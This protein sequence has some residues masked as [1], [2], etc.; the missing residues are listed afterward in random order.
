MRKVV[1]AVRHY[2]AIRARML[3]KPSANLAPGSFNPFLRGTFPHPRFLLEQSQRHGPVFKFSW[4]RNLSTAIVG[5]EAAREFLTL[6][7]GRLSGISQDLSLLGDVKHVRNLEGDVHSRCKQHLLR[8]MPNTGSKAHDADLRAH[9]QREL[10]AFADRCEREQPEADAFKHVLS[11]IATGMLITALFGLR[12]G[13]DS[14]N[15]ILKGFLK[16]GPKGL[17]WQLGP[18]QAQAY[19]ELE[20]TITELVDGMNETQL[21]QEDASFLKE[22]VRAA[23]S[24]RLVLI[25]LLAMTEMGRYDLA[26]FLRW[27]VCLLGR[28]HD[29]LSHLQEVGKRAPQELQQ[30]ASACVQECLRHVQSESLARRADTDI[31][32]RGHFIPR[33]TYVRICLW[34]THKDPAVF[35]DPFH[36]DPSRFVGKTYDANQFAPFGLDK[37]KCVAADTVMRLA[38]V[39]IEELT[40]SFTWQSLGDNAPVRPFSLWEPAPEFTVAMKRQNPVA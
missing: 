12:P 32:F 5:F 34:E 39:F 29:V 36:F 4:E 25:N 2:A 31:V 11:V 1:N 30:L 13:S 7:D 15:A 22:F 26:A 28:H 8:A 20:R 23:H 6:N 18:E 19:E 37:H 17:I 33:R 27:I 14:F 38:S 10:A 21:N 40:T 24:D 3:V 16:L 35:P 9:V